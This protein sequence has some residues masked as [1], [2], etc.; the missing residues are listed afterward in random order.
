ML[1]TTDPFI[2]LFLSLTLR[3]FVGASFQSGTH[4]ISKSISVPPTSMSPPSRSR[5][6]TVLSATSG[7]STDTKQIQFITNKR[8]PYAQ[9]AWVA[10][11]SS[12]CP[13]EMREIS[14]YGAGGKPDW[15]WKYNPAGTVPV[16]VVNGIKGEDVVFA[17][18]E[19]I[20]D[21]IGDGRISGNKNRLLVSDL[22]E[23]EI[24]RV[25]EW[26]RLISK[27]LAPVGKSAVLGGSLPKLRSLLKEMNGMVVGP[28]LAGEKMTLADCAAFPFLFRIDQEFGVGGDE[29]EDKLRAWLD[30]CMNIPSIKRT[31]PSGGWWWW[32]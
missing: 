19:L 9:K 16:V 8:C 30:K 5:H 4:I 1:V 22:S 24:S 6:S 20:L 32:W 23:E 10:L 14:L 7:I 13:Y 25:D 27:Q 17:D 12:N 3:S 21:A 29:N 18:S 31:I 11:E 28:Y 15:F 26:R 2:V